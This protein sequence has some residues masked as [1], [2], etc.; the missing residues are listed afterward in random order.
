MGIRYLPQ[1]PML[2]VT[3]AQLLEKLNNPTISGV[4]VQLIGGLS[5][6]GP[7][8]A[9]VSKREARQLVAH[10]QGVDHLEFDIAEIGNTLLIAERPCIEQPEFGTEVLHDMVDHI[11]D[12][13]MAEERR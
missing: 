1:R 6:L 8:F 13:V 3:Q 2:V 9:K 12:R 4:Y 10:F 7:T 11:N 5:A